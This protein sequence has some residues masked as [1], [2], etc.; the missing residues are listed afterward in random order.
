[1]PCGL[2]SPARPNSR[3][4]SC[5]N[6]WRLNLHKSHG[7]V[8]SLCSCRVPRSSERARPRSHCPRPSRS[9][10][11]HFCPSQVESG[12]VI[13]LAFSARAASGAV[14]SAW[15]LR[16]VSHPASTA[17]AT[18]S[19]QADAPQPHLRRCRAC[20][21]TQ[22]LVLT[23]SLRCASGLG[24]PSCHDPTRC[25]LLLQLGVAAFAAIAASISVSVAA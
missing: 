8:S 19:A 23:S 2:H 10:P 6:S 11:A 15:H 21:V 16:K 22:S 1:M 18:A 13:Y 5:L 14:L 7:G 3:A 4:N 12:N 24:L 25:L 17:P 9:S 20:L